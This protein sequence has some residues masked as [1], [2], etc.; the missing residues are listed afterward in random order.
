MNIIR[1]SPPCLFSQRGF[2]Q[3]IFS[4]VNCSTIV[5]LG[6]LL[7]SSTVI[8]PKREWGG[9]C[10]VHETTHRRVRIS[11]YGRRF[12]GPDN[13]YIYNIYMVYLYI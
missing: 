12:Y 13:R 11:F 6:L 10:G 9:G 1:N 3:V 7:D 4:L 8:G 5:L 2:S